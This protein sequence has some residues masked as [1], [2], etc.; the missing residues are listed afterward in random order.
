V[1][2]AGVSSSLSDHSPERVTVE[3]NDLDAMKTEAFE[4]HQALLRP[5]EQTAPE[6]VYFEWTVVRRH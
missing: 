6:C 4:P 1:A 3:P 2:V 5:V